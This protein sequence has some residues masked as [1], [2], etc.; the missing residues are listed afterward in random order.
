MPYFQLNPISTEKVRISKF[1]KKSL[2]KKCGYCFP[3]FSKGLN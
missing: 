2:Y 3:L 1:F